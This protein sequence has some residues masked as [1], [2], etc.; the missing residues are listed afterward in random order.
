MASLKEQLDA[1]GYDVSGMDEAAILKQLDAAGYDVSAYAPQAPAGSIGQDAM[2]ELGKS[3]LQ[4]LEDLA[5]SKILPVV[6]AAGVNAPGA[7]LT[8]M[9]ALPGG[10]PAD[11]LTGLSHLKQHPEQ[12]ET[13]LTRASAIAH[14]EAPN[15]DE[16]T[17][18]NAGK[19]AGTAMEATMPFEGVGKGVEAGVEALGNDAALGAIGKVKTLAK[20]LG[21]SNLDELGSFVMKPLT[22]GDK[23]FEPIV[24]AT[25]SPEEMLNAARE[26][27]KAAGKQLEAVSAAAD[28]GVDGVG[29]HGG[30][31]EVLDLPKLKQSVLDMKAEYEAIFP[32]LSAGVVTQYKNALLGVERLI[33]K[34]VKGNTGTMFSDLSKAKTTLGNLVYKH[35]SP[36]ESKAALNDVYHLISDTLDSGASKLEPALGKAYAQANDVYHKSVAIVDGLEGKAT[37]A[38]DLFGGG[39]TGMLA[40]TSGAITAAA[41]HSPIAAALAAAAPVV[42]KVVG[43]KIGTYAPQMI[44]SGLNK[45]APYVGNAVRG[46]AQS[47]PGIG[48]LMADALGQ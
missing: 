33:E 4:H 27:Q 25:S 34:A 12:L 3:P 23:T 24:Q 38:K 35:G 45:A 47:I 14:G 30:I 16:K 46:V 6:G 43:H 31:A 32:E 39:L 41:T 19:F 9:G 29:E 20:S 36:L 1:A 44:A 17:A 42:G 15:D 2:H 11:M 48:S 28:K 13:A 40:A 22:I 8:A 21:V 18:V 26:I 10:N 37:E 7:F 5:P